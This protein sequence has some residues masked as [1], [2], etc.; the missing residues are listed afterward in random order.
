MPYDRDRRGRFRAILQNERDSAENDREVH[1]AVPSA[2]KSS[3]NC[4]YSRGELETV[5][6]VIR[7]L[8]S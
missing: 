7:R 8:L 2:S 4:P 6:F 5:E 3:G 1:C